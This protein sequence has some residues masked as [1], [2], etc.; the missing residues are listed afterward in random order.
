M[1]LI[2]V[3]DKLDLFLITTYH[4]ISYEV[5]GASR[6]I[7]EYQPDFGSRGLSGYKSLV[8]SIG[9]VFLYLVGDYALSRADVYNMRCTA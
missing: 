6:K 1:V 8:N 3:R 9:A 7:N 5:R 4:S 2:F